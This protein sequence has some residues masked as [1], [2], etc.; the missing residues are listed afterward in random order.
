MAFR[1]KSVIDFWKSLVFLMGFLKNPSQFE[2][3]AQSESMIDFY[4]ATALP[5]KTENDLAGNFWWVF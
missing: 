3:L 1:E 2:E 5:K 4:W